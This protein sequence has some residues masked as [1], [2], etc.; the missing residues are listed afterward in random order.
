MSDMLSE[1]KKINIYT[2]NEYGSVF[3]AKKEDDESK[4]LVVFNINKNDIIDENFIKNYRLITDYNICEDENKIVVI[5]EFKKPKL[6]FTYLKDEY[7]DSKNRILIVKDFFEKLLALEN[8]SDSINDILVD[9]NQLVVENDKL[10]FNNYLFIKN[11]NKDIKREDII[12]K[13]YKIIK[14]ILNDGN[15]NTDKKDDIISY[16]ERV[17]N[18]E[19]DTFRRLAESYYSIFEFEMPYEEIV[20]NPEIIEDEILNDEISN[21]ELVEEIIDEEKNYASDEITTK[22]DLNDKEELIEDE[23]KDDEIKVEKVYEEVTKENVEIN[24]VKEN[25]EDEIIINKIYDN[26]NHQKISA[27]KVGNKKKRKNS[28]SPLLWIMFILLG[29]ITAGYYYIFHYLP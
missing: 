21:K 28:K 29:I 20:E 1:F 13:V 23:L 17:E 3:T 7:V 6:L 25:K 8:F 12:N 27:K 10:I 14:V 18:N 4:K 19:F 11:I 22:P 24:D 9:S 16:L 26:E 15:L 5:T 2:E